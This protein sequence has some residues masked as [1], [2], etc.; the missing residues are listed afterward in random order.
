MIQ[1]VRH[2]KALKRR[3][4]CSVLLVVL[5][6]HEPFD[7]IDVASA[8][9]EDFTDHVRVLHRVLPLVFLGEVLHREPRVV[10]RLDRFLAVTN[11]VDICAPTCHRKAHIKRTKRRSKNE[12]SSPNRVDREAASKEVA[13]ADRLQMS[14]YLDLSGYFGHGSALVDSNK[15]LV[16]KSIMVT[17]DSA[18]SALKKVVDLRGEKTWKKHGWFLFYNYCS[19]FSWI[20]NCKMQ[21]MWRKR[22]DLKRSVRA[23][24]HTTEWTCSLALYKPIPNTLVMKNMVLMTL[25]SHSLLAFL[26]VL[27]ADA[28]LCIA[29]ELELGDRSFLNLFD[30]GNSFPCSVIVAVS[31]IL[32][33]KDSWD[34]AGPS[35]LCGLNHVCNDSREYEAHEEVHHAGVYKVLD[36]TQVVQQEAYED[37]FEIHRAFV[38]CFCLCQI[39]IH[40][41]RLESKVSLR[42]D[43]EK[44]DE[45]K[46]NDVPVPDLSARTLLNPEAKRASRKEEH[47]LV[48]EV[49]DDEV[50]VVLVGLR[51]ELKAVYQ[52]CNKQNDERANHYLAAGRQLLLKRG[53]VSVREHIRVGTLHS[54]VTDI[55]TLSSG[56]EALH[57]RA[58]GWAASF[59]II[60]SL[61]S[62]LHHCQKV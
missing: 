2:V 56:F 14:L 4:L 59:Q 9:S 35:Q 51:F 21:G 38:G 7:L 60:Y 8:L 28:A 24:W 16:E 13:E 41:P 36:C 54:N 34:L 26:I 30:V 22:F 10:L 27:E 53:L 58:A 23:N 49:A 39:I 42:I 62:K 48:L 44:E 17:A 55:Q 18:P 52:V 32:T 40:V 61:S 47:C 29:P 43:H 1:Q 19:V 3:F 45:E 31:R 5:R 37:C 25:E 15:S 12:P 33:A 57:A 6:D 11:C 46:Y 50:L 20:S